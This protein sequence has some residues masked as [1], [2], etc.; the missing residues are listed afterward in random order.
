V[1]ETPTLKPPLV[2]PLILPSVPYTCLRIRLAL[3]PSVIQTI[4]GKGQA[5]GEADSLV[6][7]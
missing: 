1:E 6:S 4:N 2:S 5:A 7:T 3:D